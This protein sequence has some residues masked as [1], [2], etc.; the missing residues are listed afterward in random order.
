MTILLTGSTGFL[1][2]HLLI[3]LCNIGHS[4]VALK[5]SSSDTRRIHDFLNQ[6][7][8]VDADRTPFE[9]IFKE[10]YIDAVIHTAT[11]YG[12]DDESVTDI[13]NTNLSMPLELMELCTTYKT[14]AFINTD[15]FFNTETVLP[16]GLSQYV[17]SKKH[18]IEYGYALAHH[19]DLCFI[20][21]KLE[22]M[23]GS[24][25]SSTKFIPFLIR[26]FLKQESQIDLTAGE[27]LRD[28]IHVDD[29]VCA[30]E[31]LL[32]KHHEIASPV[33]EVEVGSG[34]TVPIREVVELVHSLCGAG[35]L[36]NFGGLSY[37]NGEIMNSIANN[38]FLNALG[39]TPKINL[40]E[41]LSRTIES[42][43]LLIEAV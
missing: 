16:F 39:W 2:S 4:V 41:G 37:R 34:T 33:A 42:E 10:Q 9:E 30:F 18:L 1:G 25:D 43:R 31:V 21:A 26:S 7:W 35:T 15:T 32:T 40:S 22:H 38:K 14:G 17:R 12:R 13:V 19:S 5:R 27:Q 36:L 23:Y 11:C 28:F 29:V 3:R 8:L 24:G 20:N 6:V